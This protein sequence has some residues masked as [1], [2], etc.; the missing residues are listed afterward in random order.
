MV[1]TATSMIFCHRY[2]DQLAE[3]A[4]ICGYFHYFPARF[5]DEKKQDNRCKIA[6][7]TMA[8]SS[9]SNNKK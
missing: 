6:N 4:L 3:L 1:E 7:D 8:L 2:P 5:I 9:D